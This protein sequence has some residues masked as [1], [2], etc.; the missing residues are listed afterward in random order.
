MAAF[1]ETT[2]PTRSGLSLAARV[3]GLDPRAPAAA[4][5]RYVL[6]HGWMDNCAS[7]SLLA[8][9]LLAALPPL[10]T[11]LA[12]D[13]PG[14]GLSGHVPGGF[15][16]LPLHAALVSEAL[17]LLGWESYAL[18][19]HS[20][21]GGVGLLLAGAHPARARAL[22]LLDSAG[23]LPAAPAEAPGALA[24]A[25][26]SKAALAA[27]PAASTYASPEDAVAARLATVKAYPGAQTLSP[28][29]ARALVGRMLAQK[30]GGGGWRWTFD[31][32]IKFP[33]LF[34]LQEEAVLAFCSA[35][36]SAGVPVLLL[37][38]RSGWP[39]PEPAMQARAAALQAAV[40]PLDGGHHAHADPATAPEVARLLL[41]WLKGKGMLEA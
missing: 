20:M 36:A 23:P 2:L 21:G 7:F 12:V 25:L 4:P 3:Y 35:V 33:S 8:P 6:L 11:L 31:A 40:V 26:A 15:Y 14:H 22:V 13:C 41:E 39:Y 32:H 30:D 1:S 29:A 27:R 17:E 16:T 5:H 28:E 34:S 19:C 18:V 9:A 38:A 24:R 10:A 37:R